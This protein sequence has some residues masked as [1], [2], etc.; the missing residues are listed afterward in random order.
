MP[1]SADVARILALIETEA[2]LR[3][4]ARLLELVPVNAERAARLFRRASQVRRVR[5]A[6]V[7]RCGL[8]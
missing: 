8:S 6:L 1:S 7:E 4:D 2:A 3:S 5:L